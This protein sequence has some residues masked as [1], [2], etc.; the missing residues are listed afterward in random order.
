MVVRRGERKRKGEGQGEP[1][2]RRWWFGEDVR[3][4]VR[5]L[6]RAPAFT[7]AAAGTLALGIGATTMMF[8]VVDAILLQALPYPEA[9]RLVRIGVRYEE[10]ESG[11]VSPP[12]FF[13][14]AERTETF[15][16]VAASRLQWMSWAAEGEPE[17]LDAAGVTA[18][19]FEVIG[20]VPMFGRAFRPADDRR[21]GEAVVVLSHGF[22][23][24]RFGGS[25]DVIGRSMTL[26]DGVWTI[27][28]VMPSTFRG[29]EAIYH[30]NIE[31]WFP[32]GRIDDALD[33]RGSAFLQMIGRLAEGRTIEAAH[34]ELQSIGAAIGEADAEG[35][36]RQFWLADLRERT[37][38]DAGTLLWLLFGAVGL[39]LVISCAN[40]AHLFMVRATERTRE[41]AVRAAIG[42]GRGR[43]VRQLVT[44]STVLALL[45]GVLGTL[46]A[47]AGIVAFRAFGPGDL[48]RL[49]EVSIDARVL[50]FALG[51]SLLTGI[52]FGLAPARTALRSGLTGSLRE[53][54]IALTSGRSRTRFRSTLVVVQT[55]LA[56]VLLVG[57]GLLMNSLLR[58]SRV[59]PGFDARNVVWL[60]VRLPDRYEEAERRV[61]FDA[62]LA[63]ME[64]VP[65]VRSVGGIQGK[66]LDRNRSVT[67]VLPEGETLAQAEGAPRTSWTVVTP[68]YFDAL[69]ISLLAGRTFTADDG[70]GGPDVVVVSRAFADRFW[71]RGD[72]VGKRMRM[73]QL[74]DEARYLTVAGVVDDV[75]QFGLEISAEPMVYRPYAQ[76]PRVWLGMVVRH[77]GMAAAQLIPALRQAVWLIDA[78]LPLEDFGTMD[79]HVRQSIGEPRFRVIALTTFST[80][81]TLLA[82]VG[83]YATLA[84][85]VRTRRRELGIRMALGAAAADVRRMVVVRGMVLAIAGVAIGLVAALGAGRVLA[86]MV[87]GITTSDV[88]TFALVA[89]GMIAIS[90]LAC[91]LPA[92]R[93]AATDPARILRQE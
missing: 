66:P 32:L 8:G 9:D 23:Q 1:A 68:G 2:M 13:D 57:A 91:W 25:R 52:V 72:A 18:S 64:A 60:D 53:S 22:W 75:L 84:W 29:P 3:Q 79:A 89:A 33:D 90:F 5:A 39:L 15:A 11:A 93:A 24:R 28:G 73:G 92:R 74:G 20:E 65:G 81:A 50:G 80:V 62:L 85:L 67:N 87:F 35:G 14:V 76:V 17:Q 70:P 37:V 58:L 88:S 61:F 55:S 63:R 54:G 45:A 56:L 59:D 36:R 40:V 41:I 27:V 12:D 82:F 83:L 38:N 31:L 46:L 44:E 71:P 4:A 16:A 47:W 26:N 30:G 6:G 43:I 48:P 34:A 19:Y 42:A 51:L 78:S 21:G 10:F 69:G 7:V 77:D 49:A 86:T